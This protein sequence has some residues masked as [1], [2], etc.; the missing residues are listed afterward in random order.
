M[1]LK[2]RIVFK[3]GP[4]YFKLDAQT[5]L[6]ERTEEIDENSTGLGNE[7]RHLKHMKNAEVETKLTKDMNRG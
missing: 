7:M 5:S 2:G 3:S 1:E 4:P 6:V